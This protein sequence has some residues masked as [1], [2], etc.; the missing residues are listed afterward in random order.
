MLSNIFFFGNYAVYEIM[1]KNNVEMGRTKMTVWRMRISCWITK[2]ANTHSEYVI[3]TAFPTATMVARTRLT[4]T[5]Y[6]QHISCLVMLL[7]LL[8]CTVRH[9]FSHCFLS[10]LRYSI[11]SIFHNFRLQSFSILTV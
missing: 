1:W 9:D 4:A 11:T 10:F 2:A 5:L 3:L 6:E 7:C 8:K